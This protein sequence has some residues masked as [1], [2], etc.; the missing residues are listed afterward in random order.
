MQMGQDVTVLMS[1]RDYPQ[2]FQ[3]GRN[4]LRLFSSPSLSVFIKMDMS[5][6]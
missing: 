6:E 5:G 1:L 2:A 3:A 4:V